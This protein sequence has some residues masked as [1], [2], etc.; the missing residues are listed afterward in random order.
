MN[1]RPIIV[2]ARKECT[3]GF[4]DRRSIYT[5]MC[6]VLL[7]PLLIAFLLHQL[8][9]QQKGARNMRVPVVRGELAPGLVSW[10]RQQS[11]VEIIPGPAN[12]ET[13]VRDRGIDIVLVIK[14][15]FA[16]N[17][18][19]SMSAPVEVLYD[20]TRDSSLPKV[21]RL[22][23]LLQVFSE[24][25]A[26]GRLIARGVSPEVATPLKIQPI[27]VA[28]AQRRA[29]KLLT[30]ILTVVSLGLLTMGAQIATDSTAGERERGSLEPLL[31]NPVSRWQLMG[32]K[33]LASVLWALVGLIGTLVFTWIVL[34]I[35]FPDDIDGSFHLSARH[36]VLLIA[37]MG[38]LAVM[39][40]AIQMYLSCF[41]KSFKEAQSYSIALVL[42]V[43]IIGGLSALY[44]LGGRWWMQTIPV[45]AQFSLGTEILAGKV[46]SLLVLSLAGLEGLAVAI[47][48]VWLAARLFS[49][50]K[51]IFGR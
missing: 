7:G 16:G 36:I 5:V 2:V 8:A 41:A 42:P 49:T 22:V 34:F 31:L 13:A 19:D 51:I 14:P 1:L 21:E 29:A 18:D 38:P 44:P 20:S 37:G 48:F 40:P 46:P 39:A 12:P 43:G 10:L 27:D 50:E 23:S 17:F 11:G 30:V 6:L 24:Q 3:D 26:K 45:L 4:R 28:D 47:V 35:F 33:W 9:G 25:T 15:E 32:G